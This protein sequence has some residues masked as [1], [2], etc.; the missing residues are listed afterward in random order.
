MRV[1]ANRLESAGW[2]YRVLDEPPSPRELV[3]MRVNV[4]VIDVD[5]LGR[6]ALEYV[7]RLAE[8]VPAVGLVLC[9]S[10]STVAQRV[11][12]LRLG[13][14]DWLDKPV[15]PE[16]VIARAEAVVRRGQPAVSAG[17]IVAGQLEVRADQFQAYVHGRSAELTRRE[18]ELLQLLAD[19]R[20]QVLPREDV[21]QRVWGYTMAHGDRSVD[22]FVRKLR[23][24][25][26]A[27]SPGW[28]YIHTHFGIGYRFEPA[29]R[30]GATRATAPVETAPA[31]DV[32]R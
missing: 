7:E 12:A 14:D 19:A 11:H 6:R 20:G 13:A 31:E 29:A 4:A 32:Y 30:D 21:Y 9:S 15:H 5:G 1:L 25:L 27:C 16:E 26:E 2:H 28:S 17:T 18:F 23:Q 24:K 10:P 22:V 3:D 8:S